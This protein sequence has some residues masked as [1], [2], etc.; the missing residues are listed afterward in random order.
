VPRG[1][2]F[3][4]DANAAFNSRLRCCCSLRALISAIGRRRRDQ[5]DRSID[6]IYTTAVEGESELVSGF[7]VEYYGVEF[8]LLFIAEYGRIIF[9]C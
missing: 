1:Q 3:P 9:F 2:Y 4:R 7:N 8:A 6:Y 5:T